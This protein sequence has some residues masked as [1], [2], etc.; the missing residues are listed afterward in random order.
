MSAKPTETP[1]AD[2]CLNI[3]DAVRDLVASIDRIDPERGTL[4]ENAGEGSGLLD[5]MPHRAGQH[6]AACG[7]GEER[8]VALVGDL[9]I[10]R[11]A[12][13]VLPELQNAIRADVWS[14]GSPHA[15]YMR[16]RWPRPP[17]GYQDEMFVFPEDNCLVFAREVIAGMHEAQ[18]GQ[19]APL[20]DCEGWTTAKKPS[21]AHDGGRRC[22]HRQR[23]RECGAHAAKSRGRAVDYLRRWTATTFTQLPTR[24]RCEFCYRATAEALL[25]AD[26]SDIAI[27]WSCRPTAAWD[28]ARRVTI[29]DPPA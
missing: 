24:P 3:G 10:V 8:P 1:S 2:G 21:D 9:L 12:D 28:T 26:W 13:T 27:C 19:R 6:F 7:Y 23:G 14:P 22:R 29:C 25:L 17:A 16:G 20:Q 18:S 5:D 4:W 11:V 15:R